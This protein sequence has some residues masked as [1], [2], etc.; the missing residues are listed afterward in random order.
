MF[1]QVLLIILYDY[2]N[3]KQYDKS[4]NYSIFLYNIM[5]YT[6]HFN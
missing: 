2:I 1:D 4:N 6:K 3:L 5:K